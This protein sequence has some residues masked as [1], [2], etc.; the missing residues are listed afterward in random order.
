MKQA[1]LLALTISLVILCGCSASAKYEEMFQSWRTG[2]LALEAHEIEAV[3]T[4]SDADTVCDYTLLYTV[5]GETQTIEVLA[6]ELIAR[7]CASIEKGETR[8]SF[9]GV[10]L[11][12]GSELT[13]SLSPLTSLPHLMEML[14]E[15]HLESSWRENREGIEYVVTE[16]EMPDGAILCFWQESGDMRPVYADIRGADRTELKLVFTKLT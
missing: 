12:T 10:M 13:G 5:A 15:G 7:V 9:D 2:F 4:A 16:L 11:D 1:K 14:R 6:P 8:L 3:V